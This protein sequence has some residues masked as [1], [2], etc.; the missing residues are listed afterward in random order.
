MHYHGFH[1]WAH[2][3]VGYMHLSPQVSYETA[4]AFG[5]KVGGGAD[6]IPKHSRIGFRASVDMFNTRFFKTA[7]IS[8]EVS[9]GVFITFGRP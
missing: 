2:A 9:A 8:P 7:Q 4:Q 5:Y 1:P 3:V 6:F